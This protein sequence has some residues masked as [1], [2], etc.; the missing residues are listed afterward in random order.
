MGINILFEKEIT[1]FFNNKLTKIFSNVLV[2][3]K[4]KKMLVKV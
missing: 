2:V 3:Q 4:A 1:F